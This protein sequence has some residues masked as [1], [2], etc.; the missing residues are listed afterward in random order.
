MVYVLFRCHRDAT[1]Q[2]CVQVQTAEMGSVAVLF[3]VGFHVEQ[4][5]GEFHIIAYNFVEC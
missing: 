1:I 4:T 2:L 3:S 5:V